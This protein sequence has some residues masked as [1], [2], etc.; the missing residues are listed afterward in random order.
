MLHEK[1]RQGRPHLPT[2]QASPLV[3]LKRTR[4]EITYMT[5]IS[6]KVENVRERSQKK[7]NYDMQN[8]VTC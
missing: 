4:Q 2:R 5:M 8:K 3:I 1:L 6:Y 7:C